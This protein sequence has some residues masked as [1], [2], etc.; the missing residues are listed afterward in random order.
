MTILEN[1]WFGNIAPA[2]RKLKRGSEA[3]K[4][5]EAAIANE[6]I[7]TAELSTEG[8]RAYIEY[9]KLISRISEISECDAFGK[10]FRLGAR[11][12]L[13]TLSEE[14]TQM[15]TIIDGMG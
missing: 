15:P 5:L 13:E 14:N 7:F 2:D 11:L 4:L 8:Q 10:G 9:S 3:K 6:N 12:M 1:L